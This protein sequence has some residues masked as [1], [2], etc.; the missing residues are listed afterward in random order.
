MEGGWC[1]I[2]GQMK[3]CEMDGLGGKGANLINDTP[4]LCRS[5][6]VAEGEEEGERT[7]MWE[8]G[9]RRWKE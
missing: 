1:G 4:P 5:L 8:L 2:K 6:G 3:K 7:A 9:G